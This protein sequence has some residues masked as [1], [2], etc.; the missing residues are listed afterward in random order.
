MRSVHSLVAQ[1]AKGF[2]QRDAI[3][4][5]CLL[6]AL[7]DHHVG[8]LGAASDGRDTAP[9]PKANVSDGAVSYLHRQQHDISTSGVFHRNAYVGV[10][11]FA[12]VMRVLEVAKKRRVIHRL[13]F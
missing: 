12:D 11:K 10:S 7:A 3:Q 9:G 1:T 5:A 13:R 4:R 2:D 6:D 8:E